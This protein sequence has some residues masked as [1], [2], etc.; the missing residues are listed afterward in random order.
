MR[1]LFAGRVRAQPDFAEALIVSDFVVVKDGDLERDG[2]EVLLGQ[3]EDE[4]LVPHR[5]A[6]GVTCRRLLLL[7]LLVPRHHGHL[8]VGI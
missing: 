7:R 8:H 4:R 1:L 6:A 5:V 3:V 2:V